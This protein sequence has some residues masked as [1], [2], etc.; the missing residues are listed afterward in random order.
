MLACA[1]PEQT[2][3][4]GKAIVYECWRL[5]T[6]LLAWKKEADIAIPNLGQ[7]ASSPTLDLIATTHILCVYWSMLIIVYSTLR[8]V[9]PD[10]T[11]WP[12]RTN[13]RMY[14]RQI[15]ETVSVLLAPDSGIYGVHLAN[16]PIAVAMKY[17]N[18]DVDG[19]SVPAEK[20]MLLEVLGRSS[21]GKAAGRFITS[22]QR[23][24]FGVPQDGERRV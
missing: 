4:L 5:E 20:T 15:A 22:T 10:V 17:L 14:C 23:P 13:P 9:S 11:T 18:E 16:F 7:N 19:D 24:E 12:A 2:L 6:E 21:N 1:E 3:V 8:A